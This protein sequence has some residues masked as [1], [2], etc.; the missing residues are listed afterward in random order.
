MC[1]RCGESG[2]YSCCKF[3]ENKMKDELLEVAEEFNRDYQKNIERRMLKKLSEAWFK[4]NVHV[5]LVK[6]VDDCWEEIG[7][8]EYRKTNDNHQTIINW[9]NLM[10]K[11]ALFRRWLRINTQNMK[12]EEDMWMDQM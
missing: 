4:E 7:D 5:D 10:N 12:E 1:W 6:Y 2:P 3:H 11:Y 8:N 9:R